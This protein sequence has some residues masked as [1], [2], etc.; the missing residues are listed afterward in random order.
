MKKE[1]IEDK[2]LNKLAKEYF[3]EDFSEMDPKVFNNLKNEVKR[4]IHS[5]SYKRRRRR[6]LLR[7]RFV[8]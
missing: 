7:E 3:S 4:L 6:T 2:K 5:P 8:S 1:T